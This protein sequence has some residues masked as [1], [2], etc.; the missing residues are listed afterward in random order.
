VDPK[1]LFFFFPGSGAGS[2]FDLK[3]IVQRKLTGVKN[4]LKGLSFGDGVLGIF[5]NFNGTPSW[6]LPKT[7]CRQ[8]SPKY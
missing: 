1:L 2:Y 7:F 3:G 6:I 5:L 4:K 8:L